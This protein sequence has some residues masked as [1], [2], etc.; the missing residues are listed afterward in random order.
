MFE[1]ATSE[2]RTSR[3]AAAEWTRAEED[4]GGQ[5]ERTPGTRQSPC[6]SRGSLSDVRCLLSDAKFYVT[7]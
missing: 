6:L 1:A 5:V 3:H 2:A 7:R 4:P